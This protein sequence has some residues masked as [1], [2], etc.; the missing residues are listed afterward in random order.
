LLSTLSQKC[1]FKAA[2]LKAIVGGMVACAQH[3]SARQFLNAT[4]SVCE[5]QMELEHWSDSTVKNII[6]IP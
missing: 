5:P 3:V 1:Q 2:A 4:L 6:R